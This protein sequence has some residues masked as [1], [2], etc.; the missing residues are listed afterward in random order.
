MQTNRVSRCKQCSNSAEADV[1]E[2]KH[3]RNDETSTT[4]HMQIILI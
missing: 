4:K 3:I 2:A 1:G